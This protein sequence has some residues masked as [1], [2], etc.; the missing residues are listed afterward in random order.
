MSCEQLNIG[1][2]NNVWA[3]KM[4]ADDDG[5]YL[6]SATVTFTLTTSSG[7]NVSGAVNVTMSYV[8]GSDGD[9]MG[10]LGKA[11]TALLTPGAFYFLLINVNSQQG[12]RKIEYVANYHRAR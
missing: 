7:A 10:V 4:R 6:N 11:V 1:E 9:Y 2:D 8:T 12:Y 3:L 5:D